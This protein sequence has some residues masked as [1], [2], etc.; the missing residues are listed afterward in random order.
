ME[1]NNIEYE[2]MDNLLLDIRENKYKIDEKLPSDNELAERY[3][4]PRIKVRNIYKKI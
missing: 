3:N 1:C 4:V 2:I